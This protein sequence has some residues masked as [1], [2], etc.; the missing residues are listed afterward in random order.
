ML[1]QLKTFSAIAV[2]GTAEICSLAS[3]AYGQYQSDPY[4][5][6]PSQ[7]VVYKSIPEL[8]DAAYYSN[9]GDYFYQRSVFGQL[10]NFL[11]LPR[12]S[13]QNA[14]RSGELVHILYENI[15]AVQN[16]STP[17]IRTRDLYN[18]F[19]QNLVVSPSASL[20]PEPIPPVPA[21]FVPFFAPPAPPPQPQ[22][23]PEPQL[24]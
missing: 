3:A 18:P 19:D 1:T 23:A 17:M 4:P 11:G 12:F 16:T 6:L 21:P 14:R 22:A 5:V 9:G 8:F 10:Q 13:E 2:L 7:A 20:E 15:S 24:F